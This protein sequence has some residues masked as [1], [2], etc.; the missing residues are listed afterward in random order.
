MKGK[1]IM[2]VENKETFFI[3]TFPNTFYL[4]GLE[5]YFLTSK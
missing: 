1:Q 2:F 4:I 5:G 3:V